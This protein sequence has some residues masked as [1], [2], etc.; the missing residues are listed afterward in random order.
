ML[1]DW[2]TLESP[3]TWS[4]LASFDNRGLAHGTI[5]AT[6]DSLIAVG[7]HG[8]FEGWVGLVN[9]STEIWVTER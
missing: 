6:D 9:P 8:E 5:L 7:V 4:V 1:L 3:S 2:T